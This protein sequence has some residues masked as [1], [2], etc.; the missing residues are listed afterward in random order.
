MALVDGGDLVVKALKREGVD[1]IFTLCGGHVQAI[2]DACLDEGVRVIDVRHE[3]AAGHAAEGWSRAT[4]RCG[5][6]VVTAGPGVTDCVTA[7]ANA[8]MN[9]SPMLVIGGRSPLNRFEM[10]ALQEMDHLEL[11][12]PITKWARCVYETK[13]IPEYIATAFRHAMSGRPG[14]AFLEIPSDV[15]FQKVEEAEVYFPERYRPTGRKY[16][17]PR[18]V[19]EAA[20]LLARAERPL[21]MAGSQTYW[22]E[23]HEELRQFIEKLQAPVFL[24][25]M[26][27]GSIHQEHP[28][29]FSR[30]RRLALTK[31]DVALVIGTPL[32]FRLAYGKRFSPECQLIQVDLD[33]TELGRNRDFTLAIEGDAKATLQMLLAELEGRTFRHDEWLQGLR[34]EE[35]K[36]KA[37]RAEW[38]NSDRVPIHPLRLC[39]EL[40]AFVDENTIVVGDGGDIVNLAAQV[41]PINHPGQWYDPGP[42]GTLGVGTGFCMALSCVHPGKRILMVNGDGTFG[43]NG[44]EFDTFVRFNMPVVSVVGNDRQWGQITVG[45]KMM[46]GKE[47]VVAS[48][49]GDNARYDLVVAGLGGHGEFV[50]EP[51]QIR[52]ALERAFASG[53]PACVNVIIDQEPPGIHGGYDFM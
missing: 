16:P 7:I 11:L 13:R 33:P 17:D 25:G 24:N 48:L 3:Q 8:Y 31:C 36:I 20:Q 6:A 22:D 45:Q 9:R 18:L 39:K 27:R 42:F 34:Q 30:T 32:D 15:L 28:L 37:Q 21:V 41:L 2:Y 46:Y 47:R 40:A 53:K 44:F 29:F 14:P 49:L 12:R 19:R 38:E 10:G 4:R 52:P 5:V 50:T 35:E 23:A 51:Q 26:G 43:L 1:V